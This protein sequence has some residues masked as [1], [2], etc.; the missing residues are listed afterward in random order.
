M[1]KRSLGLFKTLKIKSFA[2]TYLK[3]IMESGAV[4]NS[5]VFL[6]EKDGIHPKSES[7]VS[8]VLETIIVGKILPEPY[9]C[10]KLTAVQIITI[11]CY[12]KAKS[13]LKKITANQLRLD[14]QRIRKKQL[15]AHRTQKAKQNLRAN[16]T[17]L[18][19]P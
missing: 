15:T 3:G 8:D 7:C 14:Q 13:E 16:L 11:G 5:M 9:M 6:L 12:T 2:T 1:K 18:V 17:G 4:T 10:V 19:T